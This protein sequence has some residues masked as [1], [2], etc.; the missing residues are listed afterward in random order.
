MLLAMWLTDSVM[1]FVEEAMVALGLVP[2]LLIAAVIASTGVRMLWGRGS[3]QV[4]T[5][6]KDTMVEVTGRIT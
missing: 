3:G 2:A 4:E 5:A 1:L 6:A